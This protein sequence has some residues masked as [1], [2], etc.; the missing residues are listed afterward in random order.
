MLS[1]YSS[2]GI[3]YNILFLNPFDQT[4]YLALLEISAIF[5]TY[6]FPNNFIITRF[7]Y[8][9][10]SEEGFIIFFYY[11]IILVFQFFSVK[12]ARELWALFDSFKR[13]YYNLKMVYDEFPYPVLIISRK[14][15]HIYYKNIE[16][17]KLYEETKKQNLIMDNTNNKSFQTHSRSMSRKNQ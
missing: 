15:Y 11:W 12:S 8:N 5:L 1:S 13:S 3:V 9:L 2:V 16:A 17:D 14:Q 6:K 4:I 10:A 7:I